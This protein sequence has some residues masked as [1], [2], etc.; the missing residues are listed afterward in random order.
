MKLVVFIRLE[1]SKGF[2]LPGKP[3]S[4]KDQENLRNTD[5]KSPTNPAFA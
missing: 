3:G 2:T 5:Q 4:P 1:Q